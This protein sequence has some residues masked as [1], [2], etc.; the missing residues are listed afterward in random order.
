MQPR[1]THTGS[2]LR[3][4]QA[5]GLWHCVWGPLWPPVTGRERTDVSSR[6]G[7]DPSSPDPALPRSLSPCAG[8]GPRSHRKLCV[9]LHCGQEPCKALPMTDKQCL[10]WIKRKNKALRIIE[11]DGE[12]TGLQNES[13]RRLGLWSTNVVTNSRNNERR[14]GNGGIGRTSF[15]PP[16]AGKAAG[17]LGQGTGR[18]CV[19]PLPDKQRR[20]RKLGPFKGA[21]P[22]ASAAVAHR[23]GCSRTRMAVWDHLKGRKR[24]MVRLRSPRLHPS[25]T[26]GRSYYLFLLKPL[27]GW[28]PLTKTCVRKR[29]RCWT[30]SGRCCFAEWGTQV[31]GERK[32]F[33][34]LREFERPGEGWVGEETARQGE[35][36]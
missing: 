24:Q 28:A 15:L 23:E 22:G 3:T 18:R 10:V 19:V 32:L 11:A 34:V 27:G 17:S 6:P 8:T 13:K 5:R 16:A 20:S 36:T 26:I 12:N 25:L 4:L 14:N 21:D 2:S 31:K 9:S 29:P 7:A 30:S 1:S 35:E 33:R